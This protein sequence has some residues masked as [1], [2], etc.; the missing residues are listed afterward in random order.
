MFLPKSDKTILEFEDNRPYA[1]ECATA[2]SNRIHH[3]HQHGV[4]IFG[5]MLDVELQSRNSFA[6]RFVFAEQSFDGGT[7]ARVFLTDADI[8]HILVKHAEQFGSIFLG[9][10]GKAVEFF[11]QFDI[12][13]FEL[14]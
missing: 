9:N 4:A 14:L 11:G 13:H 12:T 3:V 2:D 5:E 8:S 10:A 7:T 1:A 6:T